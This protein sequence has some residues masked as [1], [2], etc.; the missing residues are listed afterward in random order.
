MWSQ[1]FGEDKQQQQQQQNTM[2]IT[3]AIIYARLG[4]AD[5]SIKVNDWAT[6]LIAIMINTGNAE[7]DW[8]IKWSIVYTFNETEPP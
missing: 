7:I 2:D 8:V 6:K 3:R 4:K 5:L 1:M